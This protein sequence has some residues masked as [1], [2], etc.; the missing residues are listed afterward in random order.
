MSSIRFTSIV[1]PLPWTSSIMLSASTM[2]LSSSISCIVRYR[3]RSMFVASTMLMM[4]FGCSSSMYW[5]LTSSSGLYG[6]S[7]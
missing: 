2:G 6:E 5:R 4:A 1:P 3:L 7:E